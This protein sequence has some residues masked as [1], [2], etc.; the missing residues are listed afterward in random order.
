[1][2]SDRRQLALQVP[3]SRVVDMRSY[4]L[5][6]AVWEPFISERRAFLG[7][8]FTYAWRVPSLTPQ[9]LRLCIQRSP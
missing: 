8:N 4:R 7:E 2:N 9:E 3:S 6:V 5:I 1:M